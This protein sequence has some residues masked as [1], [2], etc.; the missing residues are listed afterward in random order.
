MKEKILLKANIVLI[1]MLLLG[2]VIHVVT[3]NNYKESEKIM[4]RTIDSQNELIGDLENQ[5][6]AERGKFSGL[7]EEFHEYKES[8]SK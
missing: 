4:Q 5:I 2:I 8:Q 3:T 7:Q 1:G 6:E